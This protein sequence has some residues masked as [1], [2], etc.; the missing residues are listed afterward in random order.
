MGQDSR[1]GATLTSLVVSMQS[2]RVWQHM[3]KKAEKLEVEMGFG[4]ESEPRMAEKRLRPCGNL[5]VRVS[6]GGRKGKAAVQS[7]FYPSIVKKSKC[8]QAPRP[9]R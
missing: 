8:P 2:Q 3:T 5:Q 1:N 4:R 9:W 6:K 7:S